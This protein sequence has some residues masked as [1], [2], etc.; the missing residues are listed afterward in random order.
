MSDIFFPIF[1]ARIRFLIETPCVLLFLLHLII[2]VEKVDVDEVLLGAVVVGGGGPMMS[3][4]RR[5]SSSI[6]TYVHAHA[7]ADL[8]FYL[9]YKCIDHYIHLMTYPRLFYV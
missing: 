7:H 5:N 3:P 4:S 9:N 8:K 2:V 1:W 6:S